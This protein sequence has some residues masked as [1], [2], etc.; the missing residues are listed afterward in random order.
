MTTSNDQKWQGSRDVESVHL[1]MSGPVSANQIT[2]PK[3]N[4]W[5]KC[6][7]LPKIASYQSWFQVEAQTKRSGTA[8]GPR[9]NWCELR[10]RSLPML[11]RC[12]GQHPRGSFSVSLFAPLV[13]GM[14]SVN[15][16]SCARGWFWS[17][18]LDLTWTQRRTCSSPRISDPTGENSPWIWGTSVASLSLARNVNSRI[19][20]TFLSAA[21]QRSG[22]EATQ[23]PQ[24]RNDPGR[25]EVNGVVGDGARVQYTFQKASE[26]N[27]FGLGVLSP[28]HRSQT[29]SAAGPQ[30]ICA[31]QFQKESGCFLSASL[32]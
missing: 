28:L 12:R 10:R 15:W 24:L 26:P 16:I 23:N 7:V 13:D 21:T 32:W 4:L 8:T 27:R 17:N 6:R 5:S 30:R 20:A 2:G 14:N 18:V 3:S 31:R 19:A 1:P 22:R 25:E 9:A 29:A 11:V